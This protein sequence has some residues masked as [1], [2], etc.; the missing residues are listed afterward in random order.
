MFKV[1]IKVTIDNRR[2]WTFRTSEVIEKIIDGDTPL[3]EVYAS[4]Q[5]S[6][7]N[8]IVKVQFLDIQEVK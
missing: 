4:L 8:R 7:D 5:S 6:Y 3:K 2:G 1:L